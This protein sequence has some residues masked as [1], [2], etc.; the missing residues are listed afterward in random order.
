M[1]INEFSVLCEKYYIEP[2][3]ALE[4]EKLKQKLRLLKLGDDILNSRQLEIERMLK[5]EF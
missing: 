5:E 1:T 3:I 2:S 4:N